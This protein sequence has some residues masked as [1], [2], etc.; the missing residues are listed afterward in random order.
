MKK[1]ENVMAWNGKCPDC[2]DKEAHRE[3]FFTE[4]DKNHLTGK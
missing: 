1:G 3:N 2:R 4:M